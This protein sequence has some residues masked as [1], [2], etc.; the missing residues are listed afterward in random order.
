MLSELTIE[1]VAVIEKATVLFNK[2]FNVLTGETGAG[3]SIL[4]NSI[5]AILGNRTSKDIVRN[6]TPKA[7]IWAIFEEIPQ[8]TIQ[9]IES[10]GYPLDEKLII[11]REIFIDGKNNCRVNGKIATATILRDISQSLINI[12]GQHDNQ[13]L[14][15]SSK[16]I[17]ILDD[18]AK[19]IDILDK[20]KL[21]FRKLV[22]IEKQIKAL[23]KNEDEIEE[24]QD[25]LTFQIQEIEEAKLQENEEDIL[26]KRKNE[27][28][29][30]AKIY[31][32]LNIAYQCLYNG[33]GSALD[34]LLNAKNSLEEIQE[35]S[36]D[37]VPISEKM[38]DTYFI[39]QE[40]SDNIKQLLDSFYI[41]ENELENIEDRLDLIYKL[42]RKYGS[43]ITEILNFYENAKLE[44]EN[45]TYSQEKLESLLDER[46]ILYDIVKKLANDV[47]NTRLIAFEKLC[48]ILKETLVF[49]NM[50]N[51]DF[52][53]KHSKGTLTINGQDTIEFYIVTNKGETPKPLSKIASGGE[54]SRIM[55]A[56]KSA[57]SEADL[58]GTV[59]YD[60][61]DTGI[62]GMAAGRI[63]ETLKNT[64]KDKQVICV[65]H[66]AQI[67]AC[68]DNHLFIN[69][70]VC[71]EKTF[72]EIYTLNE[73]QKIQEVARIISGDKITKL[74][75]ASAKEMIDVMR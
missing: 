66:T 51:I 38:N 36:E 54:L 63:G 34:L 62:S 7:T 39:A 15:N 12:H 5:N 17:N 37:V 49:L 22:S 13:N 59:I 74:S 4:I 2:G 19:N 16:H 41:D 26:N 69:K 28:V 25:L 8:Q 61:I 6:G 45:T 42:K 24:K 29:H 3:K 27:I 14:L 57:L 64:A 32:N 47:S 18:Y 31:E 60:E 58:I 53:L 67:A 20:Y 35:Y 68:A 70:K 55:L 56:I 10:L 50:P 46:D 23:S 44:L 52:S 71:D 21:E 65:T 30:Q 43:S 48:K 9:I 33:E 11:Q 72:T 1:N 73:E 75:L 40:V